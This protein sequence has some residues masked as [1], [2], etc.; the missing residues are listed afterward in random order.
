MV[1]SLIV[2]YGLDSPSEDHWQQYHTRVI[3]GSTADRLLQ[4]LVYSFPQVVLRM[5]T[6]EQL[7]SR[8]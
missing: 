1:R 2:F 6:V 7:H 5:L 8:V 4:I 3:L